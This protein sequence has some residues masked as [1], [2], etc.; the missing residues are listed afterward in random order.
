MR[1][2]ARCARWF[3]ILV[4]RVCLA[5]A[6]ERLAATGAVELE[7]GDASGDAAA[8][9]PDLSRA[10]PALE[11]YERLRRTYAP[12]WPEPRTPA[13]GADRPIER[14]LEDAVA[15]LRDWEEEAGPQIRRLEENARDQGSLAELRDFLGALEDD[16]QLD[17]ATLAQ[18]RG[19]ASTSAEASLFVI[20]PE[21]PTPRSTRRLLRLRVDTAERAYLLLVGPGQDL[22]GAADALRGAGARALRLPEWLEGTAGEALGSV[23]RRIG[24]LEAAATEIRATLERTSEHHGVAP[25]LGQI[26]RLDW[27]V[28]HLPTVGVSEYL[29]RITGWTDVDAPAELTRP[30]EAADIP[31]V[32]GF[33][34]PPAEA[35]PPRLTRNPAW[36]RPFELFMR[37]MGTPAGHETDP[38]RLLAFV[39]PVLFGYMFG[40]IG[41]GAVLVLA[42]FVLKRHWPAL[43][44][45]VPGGAM[46]MVFGVLFGSVFAFEGL[47]G[48]LWLHP[49]E[50]PL[51]VLI[52]PLFAGAGLIVLGLLL[53]AVAAARRGR[54]AE[55]L[56]T[57]AGLIV[58]YAGAL[59][60]AFRLEAG[61]GVA[62]I[63]VLWY[64][65]GC[66]WDWREGAAAVAG[67]MAELLERL[68]QLAVNTLSFLR[69][70]AFALAHAGLSV[71][72]VALAQATPWLLG[73]VA[74]VVVGNLGILLLEGLVVSV[75]T[76][77]L[78]LFEFFIRF[79]RAEGRPFRPLKPPLPD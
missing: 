41:Q 60:A 19:P 22:A 27:M 68:L 17:F 36:A 57:D 35:E 38:S 62:A 76:T 6:V 14:A 39:A 5:R 79:F 47:L 15:R 71:A 13:T 51:P 11:A 44:M 72:V 56:R 73:Q 1:T 61:L 64:L 4:P 25:A 9:V 28:E 77:R 70:G 45:L 30:L 2:R 10:G 54:L 65:V 24:E 58:T 74:V 32:I 12:Y 23:E 33:P 20:D 7:T 75:Q 8:S 55:W 42:G 52:V 18:A 59:S 37:L 63:G 21:A 29:A 3:E 34:E 49:I 40:D 26:R 78:I 46:A 67:H 50:D 43:G 48:P 69:V 16:Q 66:A 31:A 53:N